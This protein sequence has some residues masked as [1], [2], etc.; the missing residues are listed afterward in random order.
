V[1]RFEQD[2][3]DAQVIMLE[4]NYRSTQVILDAAMAVIDQN[5]YRRQK[6]LRTDRGAGQKIVLHE[7]YDDRQEASYVVDTIAG[8]VTQNSV[9]PGDIAVMYRTNAQSR[10]LE[11]A[12]LRANLPYKLVG[13]QRFY[14]RR[15]IK[16]M[17]A[18][19]RLVH[20]PADEVSLLRVINVPPRR[21]G[22]KTQ[23]A[24]RTRSTQV[25]ISP[26]DLLL[27]LSRD[28]DS[29]HY[30]AFPGRSVTP[31]VAFGSLLNRWRTAHFDLTPLQ[32]MDNII[33]EI[34]YESYL[35]TGTEEG[36]S[37]WENVQELRRLAAD[38]DKKSLL[39][40]LDEVA[41]V[42]D[43]DTLD[44]SANVPTLLTLHAA[45]GLEF[46]LVFIVGLEDGTLPH[47]RSFEDPEAMAEERRLLYVGITRTKD[48]LY[49]INAL[50]RSSYGYTEPTEPSRFLQDIPPDLL[51]GR[52]TVVRE[53]RSTRGSKS[54]EWRGGALD[55]LPSPPMQARFSAGMRVRHQVWGEGMVLN[56]RLQDG[57][58]TVDIF[59]EEVGLKRV[60]ASLARLEMLT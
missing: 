45:K 29:P 11:E 40:F 28:Q 41:L 48:H 36:I 17:I 60:A 42:S 21:I 34:D 54:M 49:L 44:E 7:A 53:R 3:P 30:Q 20:N 50:N 37:R 15:E 52:S 5:P 59:F 27:D 12:F 13:A 22:T 56:S 9:N 14:G 6:K 24:L 51:D 31:L 23:A 57:D 16:D 26:G 55:S 47:V 8:M 10:L 46:P 18:Y 43:Q 19:L 32:L 1:Q 4:Q 35:D 2:Y 38:Y 39:N 25:G 33:H 58:E